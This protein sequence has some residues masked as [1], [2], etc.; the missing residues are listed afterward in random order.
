MFVKTNSTS[1]NKAILLLSAAVVSAMGC[2]PSGPRDAEESLEDRF[3]PPPPL[4]VSIGNGV[5]RGHNHQHQIIFVFGGP[6]SQKGM[7]IEELIHHFDFVSINVEEIIFTYLPNKVA[8]TVETTAEIQDMLKRDSGTLS[9]EWILTMISARLGTSMQQ[10]FV[11]DIIP[12][13][14]SI[15]KAD[16][17]YDS[18]HEKTMEQFERRYPIMFALELDVSDEV[19]LFDKNC[20]MATRDEREMKDKKHSSEMNQFVRDIDTGDKG[21]FEKRLRQYHL[22]TRPFL[23]YFAKSK[24]IVRLSL[25]ENA[26]NAVST[27]SSLMTDFGFTLQRQRPKVIA[28]AIADDSFEDIDF[29]YYKMRKIRL[30]DVIKDRNAPLTSQI[31]ALYRYISRN[32]AT[33]ENF[34][35]TL[36]NLHNSDSQKRRGINFY[37]EKVAY[38]DE[39]ITNKA[40]RRPLMRCVKCSIHSPSP[41][42]VSEVNTTLNNI[43]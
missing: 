27:V 5:L 9:I 42:K 16:S 33:D 11:I 22:C 30:S 41:Y 28:F 32:G 38:L 35:V 14:G 1:G 37:E 24:R 43:D 39:F 13:L 2:A 40:N 29:E 31:Q 34:G 25:S 15:L 26:Q 21:K 6:G 18:Q 23:E 3:A 10:R 4:P 8:N 19:A 20:N 17:F 36:D 12:T 7:I